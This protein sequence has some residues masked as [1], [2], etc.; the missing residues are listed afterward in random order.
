MKSS[1]TPFPFDQPVL[2]ASAP[3]IRL[4]SRHCTWTCRC[5]VAQ[6]LCESGHPW[7][8]AARGRATQEQLP[9]TR[10][11][12][13]TR[14]CPR[15]LR[16]WKNHRSPPCRPQS[17]RAIPFTFAPKRRW[18]PATAPPVATPTACR[19]FD[20]MCP[21]DLV[22]LIT[23]ASDSVPAITLSAEIRADSAW[24]DSCLV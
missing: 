14:A 20:A 13:A 15:P 24:H 18:A 11:H 4:H 6:G 5:R 8:S 17:T 7:R 9:R 22:K 1:H 19:D 21:L 23:F 3:A 2:V 16:G 12:V 10:P